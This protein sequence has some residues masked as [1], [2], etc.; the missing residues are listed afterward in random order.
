MNQ[1]KDIKV[2]NNIS[3]ILSKAGKTQETLAREAGLSRPHLT[4][5]INQKHS[6]TLSLAF[7]IAAALKTPF[8]QV[9]FPI[10]YLR[11]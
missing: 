4:R 9:F 7:R 5:I 6:P 1:L 10:S 3:L 8:E 2:G 11:G